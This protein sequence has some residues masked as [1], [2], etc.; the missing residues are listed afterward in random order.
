MNLTTYWRMEN[1]D[2]HMIGRPEEMSIEK[3]KRLVAWT[4]GGVPQDVQ[5]SK[6][7]AHV[8]ESTHAELVALGS[9]GGPHLWTDFTRD[10]SILL[11]PNSSALPGSQLYGS[12]TCP[13]DFISP[14]LDHLVVH[15][16][17]EV[18]GDSS[19]GE[20]SGHRVEQNPGDFGNG[21]NYASRETKDTIRVGVGIGIQLDGFEDQ[22]R[23]LIECEGVQIVSQ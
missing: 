4:W 1:S 14:P 22:V 7:A 5:G 13:R 17:M 6:S 18:S 8:C 23:S 11:G 21:D 19:N 15:S 20:I 10:D 12:E 9:P 2:H 16:P 3:K